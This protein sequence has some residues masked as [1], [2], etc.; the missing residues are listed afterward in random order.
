MGGHDQMQASAPQV[1]SPAVLRIHCAMPLHDDMRGAGSTT[2]T[3]LCSR[4]AISCTEIR[5]GTIRRVVLGSMMVVCAAVNHTTFLATRLLPACLTAA[6]W[7]VCISPHAEL[8]DREAKT[9]RFRHHQ[10]FLVTAARERNYVELSQASSASAYAM[11]WPV[12]TKRMVV[13]VHVGRGRAA[14]A[15]P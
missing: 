2:R 5:H 1:A 12:L 9:E 13:P 8:L 11:R 14:A 15:R 3:V 4:C 6:F 10:V 7:P